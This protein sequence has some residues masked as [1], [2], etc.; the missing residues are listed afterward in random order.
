MF[1][2]TT[3]VYSLSPPPL[4]LWP[5]KPIYSSPNVLWCCT[6]LCLGCST[7]PESPFS[8]FLGTI[9]HSTFTI[10]FVS[11][12]ALSFSWLVTHLNFYYFGPFSSIVFLC[13]LQSKWPLTFRLFISL[14]IY[15]MVTWSFFLY[16][17]L[18][19]SN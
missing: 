2:L 13:I 12:P 1:L 19:L 4:I 5:Y 3:P 10:L 6:G 11:H 17:S 7:F 16:S 9:T 14:D 8:P 18:F 15:L